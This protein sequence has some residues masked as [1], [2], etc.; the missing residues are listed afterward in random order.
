MNIEQEATV[1]HVSS[2]K[3][4]IGC[5][6]ILRTDDQKKSN[7]NKLSAAFLLSKE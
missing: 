5:R 4:A 3:D 2:H 7:A 1:K 6:T